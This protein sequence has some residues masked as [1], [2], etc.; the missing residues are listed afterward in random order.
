MILERKVSSKFL[1]GARKEG[2]NG[3]SYF[4]WLKESEV[5]VEGCK[6]SWKEKGTPKR[7]TPHAR[8]TKISTQIPL[9]LLTE[10]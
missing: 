5:R 2:I 3:K 9:K 1:W 7:G 6:E 8:N 4:Y 10:S